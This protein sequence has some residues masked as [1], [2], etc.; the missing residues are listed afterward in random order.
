MPMPQKNDNLEN[1]RG[2]EN[3]VIKHSFILKPLDSL[4]TEEFKQEVQK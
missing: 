3:E 1:K 4:F 2:N